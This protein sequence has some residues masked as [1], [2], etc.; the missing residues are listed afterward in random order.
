MAHKTIVLCRRRGGGACP[1]LQRHETR[2]LRSVHLV[3]GFVSHVRG[4]LPPPL[5]TQNHCFASGCWGGGL[6]ADMSAVSHSRR[7]CC[8]TQL[9]APQKVITFFGPL[10]TAK[11]S[12]AKPDDAWR[13]HAL[14]ASALLASQSQGDELGRPRT[15]WDDL[16]RSDLGRHGT[17]RNATGGGLGRLGRPGTTWDD[18]RLETT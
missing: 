13:R 18:G 1:P 9:H 5:A 4:G 11:P 8:V 16:G 12:L 17:T 6:T 14:Q 10:R 2:G 7:V 3:R 15:T